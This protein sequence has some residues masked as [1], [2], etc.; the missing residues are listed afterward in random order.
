ML[1][2]GSSWVLV[3]QGWDLLPLSAWWLG[4]FLG[5]GWARSWFWPGESSSGT[6]SLELPEGQLSSQAGPGV[7]TVYSLV[8]AQGSEVIV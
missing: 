5:G 4:L 1:V 2:V 3:R 7:A 8:F 6:A